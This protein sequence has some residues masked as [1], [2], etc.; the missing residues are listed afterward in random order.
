[1]G[2]GWEILNEEKEVMLKCSSSITDWP[3]S[4][5]AELGVILSAI[6]LVL[7]TEQKANIFTDSQAAI[8]SI[9]SIIKLIDSKLLEIML[10]KV[11]G[12]SEIKGNEEADRV[13]K[14][15]IEKSTCIKIKDV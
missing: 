5:H 11:K 14:N 4:T 3:S 13:A 12:Y 9:N 8:D 2:I 7:Q 1:M 15:D 10:I 6:L